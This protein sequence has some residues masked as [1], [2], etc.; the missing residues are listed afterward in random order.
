MKI[1]DVLSGIFFILFAGLIFFLTKDFRLMPGQNY[2][3]SFFPRTIATAMGLLGVILFIQ[4]RRS[5]DGTP[6]IQ[7]LDW[8]SSPRHVANFLLVIGALI[9]YITFSDELGFLITGFICLFSLLLWLRNPKYWR[10]SLAL[11]VVSTVALQIFFGQFLRVP[12]PWGLLQ[13]Y[14]W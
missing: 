13:E 1:N 6:L 11:S 10:G 8:V 2:G 9:F 3:A 4:G 5:R 7:V 12:L 14:A